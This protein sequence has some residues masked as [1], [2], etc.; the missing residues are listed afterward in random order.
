M[1]LSKLE[2]LPILNVLRAV[3]PI[4]TDYI[5]KLLDEDISALPSKDELAG[6][7]A[8][9]LLAI[10]SPKVY[11]RELVEVE[12]RVALATFLA[13]M[14]L[15]TVRAKKGIIPVETEESCTA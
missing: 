2:I 10:P 11:G 1:G 9:A 12:D 14:I 6:D 13:G 7:L 15:N 3:A 5:A 8:V 4:V